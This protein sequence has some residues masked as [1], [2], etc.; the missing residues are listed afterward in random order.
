MKSNHS[1]NRA[2]KTPHT[3]TLELSDL[4]YAMLTVHALQCGNRTPEDAALAAVESCVRT[5]VQIPEQEISD[6][7]ANCSTK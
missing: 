1:V 4:A 6:V 3:I 2:A 7:F 5:I